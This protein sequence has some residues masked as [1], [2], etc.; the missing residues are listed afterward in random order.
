MTS[1]DIYYRR[2]IRLIGAISTFFALI[3]FFP[4]IGDICTILYYN[5]TYINYDKYQK[6]HIVMDSLAYFAPDPESR[7]DGYSKDLDNYNTI[8]L[9]NKSRNEESVT[10]SIGKT[11]LYVWDRK[12]IDFAYP[13]KKEDKTLPAR[14]IFY[15]KA[16]IPFFWLFSILITFIM[17]KI[18][19]KSKLFKGFDH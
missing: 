6:K 12:G 1:N 13:A 10:D 18:I 8:I 3:S 9:L 7:V 16:T 15:Q 5:D 2:W 14:K 11:H 4:A 19:K 17:H